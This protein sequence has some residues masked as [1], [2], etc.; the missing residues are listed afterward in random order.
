MR[1]GATTIERRGHGQRDFAR[2][3]E[4]RPLVV[5]ILCLVPGSEGGSRP[6]AAARV[7][8]W[9]RALLPHSGHC[10]ACGNG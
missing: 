1:E 3:G 6:K 5:K 7:E 9:L 8:P 2:Q 4:G 10:S